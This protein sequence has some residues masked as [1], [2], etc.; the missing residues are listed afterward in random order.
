MAGHGFDIVSR[1]RWGAR[2]PSSRV[3]RAAATVDTVYLHWPGATSSLAGINTPAEERQ[4]MRDTQAFHMGPQ[5]G[6]S[7]FAYNYAMF[8]SGRVYAGRTLKV[9]PASQAPYNTTGV[10]ICCV[11]GPP[12][13]VT[14]AMRENLRDFV[15]WAEG[16]ARHDLHV[17]GHRQV[18][19]TTCP[20]DKLMAIVPRLDRI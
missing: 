2:A 5:R 8:P 1:T 12:D 11:I 6:W 20:G 13:P 16:Y 7:D 18:N 9:V 15:R 14:A 17:K 10:S 3:T 19:Q 4:W